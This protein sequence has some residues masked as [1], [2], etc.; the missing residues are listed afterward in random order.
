MEDKIDFSQ[1]YNLNQLKKFLNYE[2]SLSTLYF[3][4]FLAFAFIFAAF[5]AALIFTPYML[6]ILFKE[7]KKSW[8]VIFIIIVI[9]PLILLIILTFLFAFD[10]SLFLIPLGLFYFYCFLLR[11]EVNGWIRELSAKNLFLLKQK[12]KDEELKMFMKQ[13]D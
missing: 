6:Y 8:I 3:L 4:S 7:D 1:N 5:A 12:E 13:L 2:I 9:I 11:F 10:K